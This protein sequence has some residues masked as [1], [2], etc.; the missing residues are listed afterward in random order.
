MTNIDVIG[1]LLYQ[2]GLERKIKIIPPE[3]IEIDEVHFA[4]QY[5]TEALVVKTKTEDGELVA[6]IPNILLQSSLPITIWLVSG[7]QTIC[8]DILTVTPRAKPADYVYAETEVLRYE[9]LEA[10]IAA[11]ENG[12]GGSSS[13]IWTTLY[14]I[15]LEEDVNT[16]FI[17]TDME[18]NPFKAKKMRLSFIGTMTDA[19]LNLFFNGTN[20]VRMQNTY[21]YGAFKADSYIRTMIEIGE[22][23][24]SGMCKSMQITSGCT[25]ENSYNLQGAPFT[26][27]STRYTSFLDRIRMSLQTDKYFTAGTRIL[28]E[29]VLES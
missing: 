8:D 11:L 9:S 3:G 4:H 18:G 13:E 24:A 23:L 25:M 2:W 21:F 26:A 12:G 6:D 27:L 5:D 20:E 7:N 15:T 16:I 1:P 10:R 29:G 14:D 28:I 19:R 17:N 22:Q